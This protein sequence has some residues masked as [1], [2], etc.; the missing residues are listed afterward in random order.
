[1]IGSSNMAA[2]RLTQRRHS[3]QEPLQAPFSP[4]LCIILLFCLCFSASMPCRW[5]A[6][7][8]PGGKQLALLRC[9]PYGE[10]YSG[11]RPFC[12]LAI[13]CS[14]EQWNISII[15]VQLEGVAA[16][17]ILRGALALML[18][19]IATKALDANYASLLTDASDRYHVFHSTKRMI[20]PPATSDVMA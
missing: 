6:T 4:D 7:T 2:L 15:M 16:E 10:G 20:R 1:M 11:K 12:C 5:G 13:S 9:C 3:A 17:D 8:C 19:S 14:G 18:R